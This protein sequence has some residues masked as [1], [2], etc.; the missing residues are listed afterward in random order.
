MHSET[1]VLGKL[2]DFW[3]RLLRSLSMSCIYVLDAFFCTFTMINV[4]V[5]SFVYLHG[6]FA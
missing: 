6:M 2:L 4:N 1:T 5:S 3:S